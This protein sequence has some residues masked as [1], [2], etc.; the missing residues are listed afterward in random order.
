[1]NSLVYLQCKKRRTHMQKS[2]RNVLAFIL[3][4][5]MPYFI[6]STAHI[7]FSRPVVF[8][9]DG[10]SWFNGQCFFFLSGSLFWSLP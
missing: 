4:S 7:L 9:M 6:S 8:E 1:M 3:F 10:T 2:P 5:F